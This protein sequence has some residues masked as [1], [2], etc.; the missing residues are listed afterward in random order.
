MKQKIYIK[1]VVWD[2][3]NLYKDLIQVLKLSFRHIQCHIWFG[4]IKRFIRDDGIIKVSR[5]IKEL[6]VKVNELKKQNLIKNGKEISINEI[7]KELNV[8]KEDIIMAEE[9][10][11]CVESIESN[12]NLGQDNNK[13]IGL[14]EKLSNGQDEQ[15]NVTNK[16]MVEE[17]I[18][19]LKNNEKEII[20]L[21]FYKEK[22]QS[23]IAKILGI[24]QVQVSRIEKR[25]LGDLREKL[26]C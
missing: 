24:S 9:S 18:N 10:F 25:V 13:K 1:L 5:S 7:A 12:K 8:S 11:N 14:I 26:I 23:E 20:L 16:V 22:T 4:E 21:R 19:S 17:L 2:S 6:G 3:L 15:E